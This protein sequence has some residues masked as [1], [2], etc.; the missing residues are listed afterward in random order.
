[1]SDL[2][3]RQYAME[4]VACEL[5]NKLDISEQFAIDIV[6]VINSVPSATD[7]IPCSERLPKYDC[8]YLVW[9]EDELNH[10][11]VIPY[12]TVAEAFGWWI[13]HHDP[14]SL[15][16]IDSEFTKAE[17]VTAW[18]PLPQPYRKGGTE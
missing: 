6:S 2:I 18:Q 5:V 16:F 8:D 10:Y 9:S 3:S 1:M 13:D 12:D 14:I 17:N 4:A 11:A 15:G 7:W